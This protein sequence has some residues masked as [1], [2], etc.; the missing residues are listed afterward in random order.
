LFYK[1]EAFMNARPNRYAAKS[2]KF[3]PG[4]KNMKH[5]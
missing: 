1:D 3:E 2:V 5:K 4:I